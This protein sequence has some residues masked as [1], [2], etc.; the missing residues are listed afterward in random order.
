MALFPSVFPAFVAYWQKLDIG[1]KQIYYSNIAYW[2]EQ[3]HKL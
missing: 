2:T 1:A 3:K